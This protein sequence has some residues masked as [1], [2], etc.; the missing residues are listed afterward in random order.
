MIHHSQENLWALR[1]FWHDV[2]VLQVAESCWMH[3][4]KSKK[5]LG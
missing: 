5:G 4:F 3:C 1:G 2:W